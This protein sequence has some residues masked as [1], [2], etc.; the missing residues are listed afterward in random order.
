MKLKN[1]EILKGKKILKNYGY[2]N[3][4]IILFIVRDSTYLKSIYNNKDIA[5]N[6]HSHRDDIIE[7]Y[8]TAMLFLANKGYLVIR[9]GKKVKKKMSI[10]HKNIIDYPFCKFKSDFM[11][12]FLAHQAYFGVTNLTG[13]DALFVIFRKPMLCL[14]SLPIGCMFTSS[15]N[16][17]NTIYYHYCKKLKRNLSISEIFER[18]LAFSFSSFDFKNKGIKINKF[19]SHEIKQ[20]SV[21]MLNFIEKKFFFKKNKI[22]K[23]ANLLY[24]N[25]IKK[26]DSNNKYHGKIN[27]YFSNYFLKKNFKSM[28]K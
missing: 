17:L 14:G 3:K 5:V 20:F 7:N 13:Y 18:D 26:Y 25:L 4:K 6:Y 10:K 19:S 11:D 22:N 12:I 2:E 16:Y 23:K 9:M 1:E 28:I 8:Y 27:S 15:K 21:D 24:K